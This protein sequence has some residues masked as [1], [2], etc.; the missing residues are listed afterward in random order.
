MVWGLPLALIVCFL[1]GCGSARQNAGR[2]E[3]SLPVRYDREV[4]LRL[5][6]I[7][8]G[9]VGSMELRDPVSALSLA[10][11][12]LLILD[13]SVPRLILLAPD[14]R[15]VREAGMSG[16]GEAQLIRPRWVRAGF[17]LTFSV[18]TQ[19]GQL[20]TYDSQL[21]FVQSRDPATEASG[22][23]GGNLSGLAMAATG[24]TYVADRD[25]DIVYHFDPSGRFRETIGGADAGLG[26]L[27]RPQGLTVAEDGRLVVCDTGARRLVV[28]DQTGQY[29]FSLG[30]GE[31][32]GPIAV[33]LTPDE[34]AV[35]VC[36]GKEPRLALY[37]LEGKLLSSWDGLAFVPDGFGE[38]ADV[39]VADSSL[40]VVDSGHRRV[41]RFNVA[42][43]SR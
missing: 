24:D 29:L 27:N 3:H 39:A 1:L 5:D 32:Q 12:E 41:L 4:T 25:N 42:P 26:R 31:L 33:A 43:G 16:L 20:M 7:I 6:E 37:S 21:R 38:L 17:G 2:E 22:F 14:R 19:R 30:E 15:V 40:W 9:T 10:S 23:S 35:F 36:D 13:R 8:S 28:F 34:R 11:G 18:A